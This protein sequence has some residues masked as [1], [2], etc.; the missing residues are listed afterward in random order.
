MKPSSPAFNAG[1]GRVA[2]REAWEGPAGATTQKAKLQ[3]TC[4]RGWGSV[5]AQGRVCLQPS[6][7]GCPLTHTFFIVSSMDLPPF[8][9]LVDLRIQFRLAMLCHF[10]S[11][12]FRWKAFANIRT[13]SYR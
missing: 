9:G 2:R 12:S 7:S 6:S 4:S 8:H 11:S 10:R 13:L 1:K 5:Y 3:S